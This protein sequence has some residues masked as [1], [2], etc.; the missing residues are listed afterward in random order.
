[1]K[2]LRIQITINYIW[3]WNIWMDLNYYKLKIRTLILYGDY[4][5]ISC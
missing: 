1:M 4:F 2:L 3:F 5:E